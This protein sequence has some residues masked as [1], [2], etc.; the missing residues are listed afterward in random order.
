[1][2]RPIYV[3]PHGSHLGGKMNIPIEA[4][5]HVYIYFFLRQNRMA[6]SRKSDLIFDMLLLLQNY[7]MFHVSLY[8]SLLSMLS[9]AIKK[10]YFWIIEQS[11][12]YFFSKLNQCLTNRH[13]DYI[14]SQWAKY[15]I[16]QSLILLYFF[17]YDLFIFQKF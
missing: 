6:W 1:M 15:I 16:I 5:Q 17:Q 3:D 2:S 12:I 13:L 9:L 7:N 8:F 14:K 11:C 10:F 4:K